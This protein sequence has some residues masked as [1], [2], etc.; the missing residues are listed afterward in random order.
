MPVKNRRL[1]LSLILFPCL[2]KANSLPSECPG[3]ISVSSY[4]DAVNITKAS[5]FRGFLAFC[6][7]AQL[8]DHRAQ[9]QVAKTY[10][11]GIERKLPSSLE[12][13]YQWAYISHISA[14]QSRKER[15]IK[16]LQGQLDTDTIK[17]LEQG[18]IE[19][20]SIHRTGRQIE[21]HGSRVKKRKTTET[22]SHIPGKD[23]GARQVN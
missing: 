12:N 7:L 16:E 19:W 2:L 20:V 13:A 11:K 17:A 9:Y 10:A 15:L 14:A 5:P 21:G 8:G 6:H 18:A 23:T 3:D 22:G 4:L 1:I